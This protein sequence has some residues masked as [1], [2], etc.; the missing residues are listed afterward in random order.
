MNTAA[1]A[2]EAAPMGL[3]KLAREGNPEAV[4]QLADWFGDRDR[5]ADMVMLRVLAA[6]FEVRVIQ[7]RLVRDLLE[8]I[9]PDL[10]E[11]QDR[12]QPTVTMR[13]YLGVRGFPI[14]AKPIGPGS[15]K[16]GML[17]VTPTDGEYEGRTAAAMKRL[18]AAAF[19]RLF[20]R[21][22]YQNVPISDA[23]RQ[24]EELLEGIG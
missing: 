1:T 11:E 22:E 23:G 3:V 15:S 18:M 12:D 19:P 7:A 5:H 10:E 21:V 20:I 9:D 16:P 8:L 24:A 14:V 13:W 4:R 17:L 2:T 6:E